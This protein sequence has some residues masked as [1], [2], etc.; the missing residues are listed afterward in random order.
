MSVKKGLK[1]TSRRADVIQC[2]FSKEKM[3]MKFNFKS[4]NHRL[5]V[6]CRHQGTEPL[7]SNLCHSSLV[8]DDLQLCNPEFLRDSE[9][10]E[11]C[12]NTVFTV[13]HAGV[14]LEVPVQLCGCL[15]VCIQWCRQIGPGRPCH[16]RA[17]EQRQ[18]YWDWLAWGLWRP[19][20][21]HTDYCREVLG[22]SIW[23]LPLRPTL[24]FSSEVCGA[25]VQA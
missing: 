21:T 24:D 19:F 5:L 2:R 13:T 3:F 22:T 7:Y 11:F 17:P 15:K 23:T 6:F 10:T 9:R 12:P 14:G 16:S 25:L 20:R 4:P 8:S 18:I 1:T